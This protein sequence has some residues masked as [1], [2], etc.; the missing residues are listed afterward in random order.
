VELR[1]SHSREEALMDEAFTGPDTSTALA[2]ERTRAAA[3]RTLMAWIR[4]CLA[5]IT[6]GLGIGKAVE[7]VDGAFPARER[8]V[9]PR[10]I[11]LVV[12]ISLVVVGVLGLLGVIQHGVGLKALGQASY[13]YKPRTMVVAVL[14]LVFGLLVLAGLIITIP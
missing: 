2:I 7:L 4:T 3:D 8:L 11:T 13:A 1:F 6:F 5:M 10:H 14:V 12:A 9:D